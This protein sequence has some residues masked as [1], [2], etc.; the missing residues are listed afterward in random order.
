MKTILEMRES[1]QALVAK[2]R[3]ALDK[4]DG[5]DEARAAE[6]EQQHDGWMKEHDELE[7]RIQRQERLEQA[8]KRFSEPAPAGT[9]VAG[10]DDEAMT[11]ERAF[12][13]FV[14]EG[15]S[16]LTPEAKQALR[17]V[18]AQST[19][20]TEGGETVPEGFMAEVVRSMAEY[21]PMWDTNF[22]RQLP[23]AS[24]NDLPF[25]TN[26]DTANKGA[27][28]AENTQ[29]SEQDLTTG[30]II[31]GAFKYTS[32]I[33]RVSEELL[34]DSGI[35]LEAFLADALGERLGRIANESLTVGTG[36]AQPNGIVTASTSGHT[37]A[38]NSAITFDEIIDLMH[39]VD[40]AYRRHPSCAFMFNDATL[41]AV[42]KLKDSDGRYL[43][44]P[45]I[46]REDVP[47]TILGQPYL[48]NQDVADIGASARSM[49]FGRM[50][51]Y[52]VRRVRDFSL[53]RLV[54]RYA[55]FDQV[56]FVAFMRWDGDLLDTAAVKHLVHP[57]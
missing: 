26:N 35:A 5:A 7:E 21:G 53:R 12:W 9:G 28:I 14:R 1:Q 27:L 39:S 29:A 22:V 41:K 38:S 51:K 36:S 52:V 3:E 31:L 30:N 4:L 49:I 32:N 23:T 47:A 34:Q 11:H 6:L 37:A 42:R 44:N 46:P 40:P 13:Q 48:I 10:A 54:E 19:A 56:G 8:E 45:A 20:A 55:D 2:A 15:R 43:W 33:V 18:R 25:P 17:E 50:D 16:A 57:A 24:G